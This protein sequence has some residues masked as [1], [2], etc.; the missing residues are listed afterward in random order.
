MFVYGLNEW[1]KLFT[2]RQ[3]VALATFSDLLSEVAV[4]VRSS[5]SATK[6]PTDATRLRDGGRGAHAYADAVV[7]YLALG[8][9]RLTDMCNTLCRWE[10][11]RTQV[12]NLFSRQAIPMIWDFAENNVFNDAGGDFR[13]SLRS[14][15]RAL[16][17][18]PVTDMGRIAQRDA[19]ARVRESRGAA[20]STDPPYYDNISYA[21]LS[22][23]FYVWLRR[24]LAD[25]WPDE[26]STLLTPKSARG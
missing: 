20:I 7:T 15:T 26:C 14:V 18:L 9:S 1:W 11:S 2:P 22:D 23:F 16:E 10:S 8:I 13:T 21:D 5:A 6:L 3:L 17:R 12:R 4:Q 25:A 19:R 24:N